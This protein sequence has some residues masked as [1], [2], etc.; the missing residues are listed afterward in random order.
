MRLQSRTAVYT[1]IAKTATDTDIRYYFHLFP[2]TSYQIFANLS[3]FSSS[4]PQVHLT[5]LYLLPCR[6]PPDQSSHSLSVI[7]H[8]ICTAKATA[9]TATAAKTGNSIRPPALAVCSTTG[10]LV[11]PLEATPVE[12]VAV[13]FAVTKPAATKLVVCVSSL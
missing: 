13:G 5:A 9:P 1:A 2:T 11:V 6:P 7:S 12:V 10:A 8:H 3:S 4:V